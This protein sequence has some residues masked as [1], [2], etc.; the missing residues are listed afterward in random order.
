MTHCAVLCMYQEAV[1]DENHHHSQ[2]QEFL[3][4]VK[5]QVK[6]H[7]YSLSKHE[8]SRLKVATLPN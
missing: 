1:Q 7:K 4:F 8:R 2:S 5:Q 3:S 6:A